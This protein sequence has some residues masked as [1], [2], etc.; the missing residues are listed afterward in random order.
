MTPLAASARHQAIDPKEVAA[1]IR[2]LKQLPLDTAVANARTWYSCLPYCILAAVFSINARYSV[3]RQMLLRY[4]ELYGYPP[5]NVVRLPRGT[6]EP[7]VSEFIRQ[8]EKVGPERFA[9]EVLR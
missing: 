5:L 2:A 1:L 7:T 9:K 8:V 3:I 6:R 4:G